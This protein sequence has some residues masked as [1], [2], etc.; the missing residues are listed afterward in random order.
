MVVVLKNVNI[1]VLV[2]VTVAVGVACAL[3]ELSKTSPVKISNDTTKNTYGS[4]IF[5]FLT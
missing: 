3:T 5:I 1:D 4:R 2:T